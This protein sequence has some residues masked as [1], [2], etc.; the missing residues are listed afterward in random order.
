MPSETQPNILLVLTDQQRPDWVGT[1]DVPVRTPNY[2]RLVER[3]VEFSNAV[4]PAP[5]CGPSRICLAGGTEYDRCGVRGNNNYPGHRPTLY[6]R[7]RREAG[8]RTI[9]IGDLDL[10]RS[11]YWGLDGGHQLDEI[12]FDDGIE[13]PGKNA[14]MKTYRNHI[15]SRAEG[16][17]GS[18]DPEDVPPDVNPEPGHPANAYMAYLRERGLLDT[19][20]EDM[21]GR[22]IPERPVS[23]YSVT[24][25]TSLPE[26]AYV[27]NWV[28]RHGVEHLREALEGQP[29]HLVVNFVGPHGPMDVTEEMHGW[30]R[31]PDVEFPEPIDPDGQLDSE[32]HQEIR[33]NY[34]AMCENID[35][36]LGC[37]LDILEERGELDDTIVAFSSDHGEL[38]G[39]HGS[40]GKKSPLRASSGIP[41]GIA[42]PGIESRGAVEDPVGL[43]D[44]HPTFLEYAGVDRG[45]CDGVSLRPFLAGETDSHRSAVRS[46]LQNWRMVF[47]GRHELIVGDDL[48][49]VNGFSEDASSPTLF[50]LHADPEERENV[51]EDKP[52]V[53]EDLADHL[54]EGFGTDAA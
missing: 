11:P 39:D 18:Y 50:D 29:W 54:P 6:E 34:A 28:G 20:V 1:A 4:C 7:L 21:L 35:R 46:G 51:A 8:Y 48:A 3:G 53:V 14:M 40:W 27:D 24:G 16:N 17:A 49:D 5:L 32:T 22:W 44:L 41:L 13:I 2:D 12:G 30:Y 45:D 33:R 38:L 47:D 10:I 36:W 31:D 15:R 19:Y 26:E 42:G 25:P 37:Y 23:A 9:G 43:L 52:D